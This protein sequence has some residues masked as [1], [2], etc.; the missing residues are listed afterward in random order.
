MKNVSIIIYLYRN[1]IKWMKIPI[2]FL[3][4]IFIAFGFGTYSFIGRYQELSGNDDMMACITSWTPK[5]V[6]T[7]VLVGTDEN[8]LDVLTYGYKSSEGEIYYKNVPTLE[9]KDTST[10]ID[11]LYL[12]ESPEICVFYETYR[13]SEKYCLITL[14]LFIIFLFVLLVM[15]IFQFRMYSLGNMKLYRVYVD[16]IKS[17]KESGLIETFFFRFLKP[18][19]LKVTIYDEGRRVVLSDKYFINRLTNT[20]RIKEDDLID[21]YYSVDKNRCIAMIK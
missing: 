20:L 11:V 17:A 5:T 7:A 18:I 8:N 6:T 12:D 3:F 14:I 2:C 15:P 1:W 10:V 21:V 19:R 16:E 9:V 13:L 4:V